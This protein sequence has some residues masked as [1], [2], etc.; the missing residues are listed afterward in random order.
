MNRTARTTLSWLLSLGLTGMAWAAEPPT[1]EAGA[2]PPVAASGKM[3]RDG[4]S[5]EF[6]AR[7]LAGA[8]LVE[9]EPI[10]VRFTITDAS[11]GQ[12]ITGLRPG[13]WMDLAQVVAGRGDDQK[14][15]REKI[16]L[17]MKGVLGVRPMVDLNSYYILILNK[18]PSISVVDPLVSVAGTTSTMARV[19]LKSPPM[20]W[21]KSADNRH[22]FVSMPLV[23]QVAVVDTVGFRTLM[24][25]D[26]GADPVRLA[27]Q[28]DGRY[29]WVGNNSRLEGSSGVTVIDAIDFKPVK[30]FTTGRGHHEIA[31]SE[32]SRHAFVTNRDSGTVT[33]I[34]I[35]TLEKVRDMRT[36]PRPISVAY[37]SLSKAI[38]VSD[39]QAGTITAIDAQTL[40]T[41]KV[42]QAKPG[43]GPLRFTRDGRFGFALNTPENTA[44]V[45]DA[46]TD[47]AIQ[48]IDVTAEPF[49]VTFTDAYA[50]IRG[51]ASEFV[52]MV[53][54]GTL[55]KGAPPTLMRFAAGPDAPKI[56]GDL[57]LADSIATRN[58]EHSVFIVNPVNNTTYYYMQGMSAPMTGYLNRGFTARAVKVVERNMQEVEPGVFQTRVAMPTAGNFD[59]AFM[60][61]R[62]Q[63]LHCFQAEVKAGEAT[64]ARFAAPRLEFIVDGPTVEARTTV[65]VR[66]RLVQGQRDLPRTGLSDLKVSY[67]LAP[68][69]PRKEAAVT[70]I[71]DGVYEARLDIAETGAYYVYVDSP[72]VALHSGGQ[73]YLTLRAVAPAKAAK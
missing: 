48:T 57:L 39:G 49:Q 13:A 52:T 36:G 68:T 53:E 32:D 22:I 2:S 4:V 28:P 40:E 34:D 46:A 51:L 71:G 26:A 64:E 35:A 9:G 5:I 65:P 6:E 12:P 17:Y 33:V 18:D 56:A 44:T 72:S 47:E 30:S 37:S 25:I 60:L 23:G 58:D 59:V 24:D 41:R 10:D 21:V 54:L 67:F 69:S 3:V 73:P 66:F 11:S 16:A 42:I 45:I 61:D 29:L 1:V 70:E 20:D 15:C 19:I 62:P 27:L 50:Y 63:I 55:G 31:F 38:Y 7:P 8:E 43:L 14:D